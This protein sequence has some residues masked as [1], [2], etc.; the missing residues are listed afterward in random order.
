MEKDA[1]EIVANELIRCFMKFKKIEW[2]KGSFDGIKKSE[3]FLLKEM[4]GLMKDNSNGVKTSELSSKL[5]VTPAAVTHI[6]NSLEA[7]GFVERNQEPKDRRI[8][9]VRPTEKGEQ[10]VMLAKEKMSKNFQEMVDFLGVED[11]KELT[12]LLSSIYEYF[13]KKNNCNCN[14]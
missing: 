9:L 1:K 11:S 7:G 14:K 10:V 13:D 6:I 2:H 8:V 5:Q 12:R 4:I 3:I